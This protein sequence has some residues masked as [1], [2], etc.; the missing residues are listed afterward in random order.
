MPIVFN[1][2]TKYAEELRKWEQHHTRYSVTPE[3]TSEPGN[4]Y[5][6]R[7]YPKMLYRAQVRN[8]RGMCL[9]PPPSPYDFDRPDAYERA[10]LAHEAFNRSCYRIVKDESDELVAKGQGWCETAKEAMER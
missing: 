3:G 7:E 5:V 1:P 2:S 9:E 4:P 6:Y 8:G 10:C